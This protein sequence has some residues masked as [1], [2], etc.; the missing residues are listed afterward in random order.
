MLNNALSTCK[1]VIGSY[2]H[3]CKYTLV[4]CLMFIRYCFSLTIQAVLHISAG[5]L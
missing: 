1:E 3:C 4:Q 2:L 5:V